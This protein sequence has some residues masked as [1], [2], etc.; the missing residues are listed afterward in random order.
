MKD[1]NQPYGCFFLLHRQH[2]HCSVVVA[3]N[4]NL[5]SENQPLLPLPV[6]TVGMPK[7]CSTTLFN[8]FQCTG[9][10]SPHWNV[11]ENICTRDAASVGLPPIATCAL[12]T[13]AFMQVDV[14]LPM[15]FTVCR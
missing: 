15:G 1:N 8:F 4:H 6:M 2:H 9:L 14:E 12:H 7:C 13:K 10:N 11:E 5:N 3:A